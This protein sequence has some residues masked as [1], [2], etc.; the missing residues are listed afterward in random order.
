MST[1]SKTRTLSDEELD[2][3]AQQFR[4]L[5][6]PM[7][8]RILQTICKKPLTVNEIVE[9]TGATQSNISKHLSLLASSGIIRREKNAQFVY[10]S[11]RDPMT[12][13]LCEL[14][15]GKVSEKD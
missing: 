6:E 5:G 15:H 1:A 4:L 2:R 7:R 8:L 14:V 11:L 10:Y 3:V 12:M 13:K 9:A